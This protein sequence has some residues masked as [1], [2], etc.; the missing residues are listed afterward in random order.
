MTDALQKASNSC[1]EKVAVVWQERPGIAGG[2]RLREMISKALEE[3]LPV[4]G[5]S[6]GLSTLDSPD[7]DVVENTRSV[8]AS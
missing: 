3:I 7:R 1:G 8:Q 2:F 5:A 4:P 6:E